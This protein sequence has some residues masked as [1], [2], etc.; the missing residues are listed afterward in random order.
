MEFARPA[1]WSLGLGLDT[2]NFDNGQ[3]LA[4]T[5]RRN[6]V[7]HSGTYPILAFQRRRSKRIIKLK[8]VISCH[9]KCAYPFS[10]G[11]RPFLTSR[12]DFTLSLI[13]HSNRIQLPPIWLQMII[14][15][16][17]VR[18]CSRSRPHFFN[19]HKRSATSYTTTSSQT[20]VSLT[21]S[22]RERAVRHIELNTCIRHRITCISGN[23]Q[24]RYGC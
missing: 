3:R 5:G 24:N 20:R 14:I 10:D 13:R 17:S 6:I 12:S 15:S 19:S 22:S 18:I 8:R 23:L 2:G 7:K 4:S 11:R 21:G 9:S 1:V 16:L